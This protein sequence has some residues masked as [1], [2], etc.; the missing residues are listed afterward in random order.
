MFTFCFIQTGL[1]M[2]AMGD[3]N[4]QL[5]EAAWNGRDQEV[6]RCLAQGANVDATN[7]YV[8]IAYLLLSCN[9]ISDLIHKTYYL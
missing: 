7:D 4:K 8:R 1:G 2:A 5:S 3:I 6:T 9:K